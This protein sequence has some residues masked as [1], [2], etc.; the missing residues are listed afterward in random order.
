MKVSVVIPC[1]NEEK[2]IKACI[3]A[4]YSNSL[5]N[6]NNIE[7]LV[8]DGMS[9]DNTR[10]ILTE[11]ISTYPSLKIID[12]QNKITP[13]AFNLGIENATG[14]F[15][16]IIGARQIIS[17]NYLEQAVAFLEKNN[18]VW[19]IGGTVENIHENST[20][21]IISKA[22]DT[23]FGVGGGNFRILKKSTFVDTVGTPMYPKWVFKKIGLFDEAL[24]RNQDDEFNYRVT[25]NGGKI[26][27]NTEIS[28]KYYVRGEYNKLFKQYYQYGYWKVY[29]NKKVGAITSI[30]QLTP[31]ILVSSIII[32]AFLAFIH[33][34]LS[35]SYP[36]GVSLY[37]LGAIYFSLKK[38]KSFVEFISIIFT[39]YILHFSYGFGY[40]KGIL[41]FILLKKGPSS[42]NVELSR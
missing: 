10:L 42:K 36:I 13:T 35:Y 38:S 37:L 18:D 4:I 16:Q 41:D 2:N 9:N 12:N 24:V 11:L 17:E 33:P 23:P 22:M 8:I 31:P 39:F 30:R 40:L 7:V 15:I 14:E 32:G 25:S 27:L 34:I 29:V 21:E 19:C 3:E 5:Y 1:R 20:S 6:D 26:Y 28:L